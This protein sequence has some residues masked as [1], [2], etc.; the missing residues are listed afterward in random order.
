MQKLDCRRHRRRCRFGTT[1]IARVHR[2]DVAISWTISQRKLFESFFMDWPGLIHLSVAFFHLKCQMFLYR[3]PCQ[4]V[5]YGSVAKWKNGQMNKWFLDLFQTMIVRTLVHKAEGHGFCSIRL[6]L[7][8]LLFSL[9]I[10]H[11]WCQG[12]KMKIA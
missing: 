6:L 1:S 12:Y 9:K 8:S 10:Y 7:V 4:V 5:E 3:K 11:Y 2:R